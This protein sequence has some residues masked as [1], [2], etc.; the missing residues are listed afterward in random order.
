MQSPGEIFISH[1]EPINLGFSDSKSFGGWAE[2]ASMGILA[3]HA[4][5]LEDHVRSLVKKQC[6]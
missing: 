5:T 3:E 1:E 4:E 2:A 6:T